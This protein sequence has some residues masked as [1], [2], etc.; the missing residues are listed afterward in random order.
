[1]PRSEGPFDRLLRRRAE[2]DPAP[3]IIGGTIAFLALVIILVF[4][5]SSI[6][7][8]GGGSS[9]STTNTGSGGN[10]VQVGQGITARKASIPG[11]P[12]G[13]AAASDYIELQTDQ[14]VPASI[15]LQLKDAAPDATGLGFYTF[16]EGRWQRLADVKLEQSGRVAS[17]DF[18]SVPKNLAVLRV[19]SQ[20][21]QIAAALPHGGSL[22]QDARA[23]IVSPRDYAPASDGSIQGTATTVSTGG[24]ILLMPTVIGSSKETAT[25]VNGILTDD[26]SRGKHADAIVA[27]AQT[28][29]LGG[30]DLE[31]SSVDQGL[32]DQFTSFVKTVA[33]GL[34]RANKKLS[35]TLP[36]PSNQQQAYD[37]KALGQ[38]ADYIKILPIAD[39]VSYWQT[40]PDSLGRATQDIDPAKLMLVVSPFSVVQAGDSAQPI[41]YVQ[42]MSL[43][44]EAVVREPQSPNDIKPGVTVRLVATN[45]DEGEGASPLRWNDD[46]AAVTFAAGG[47][48]RRRIFIENSFSFG[49]KLELIQAY[50]LGGIAV[51]DGSAQS[52]VA[53]IWPSVSELASAA[54]VSLQRPNDATFLPTWQAPEGGEL[55]AG[56]GTT[57]TWVA[58]AAGQ[59]NLVLVVSDGE[60]RFGRKT[61]VEVKGPTGPSPTPLLTFAPETGT[62]TPTEEAGTETPTPA[63]GPS[64]T[65]IKA[66][67]PTVPAGS[68]ITYTVTVENTGSVPVIIISITDDTYPG[69]TCE[70]TGGADIVGSELAPGDVLNC[71]FVEEAP[72]GPGKTVTDIVT[73]TAEDADG[74]PAT[75]SDPAVVQTT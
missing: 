59:Y 39:P 40:M 44:A 68:Q 9:G 72:A 66:S 69:V 42:A 33:D 62:P 45:L 5:F 21:Y 7:G 53:N 8:G 46:A 58:P 25:I 41:G 67:D 63:P 1:V 23:N 36:P 50:G 20:T 3:I 43:A 29:N 17:G 31:Y 75:D 52:D 13:L 47:N 2:R 14:D 37:W 4:A 38:A 35:L 54:T 73:V 32:K 30:V 26:S 16:F 60:R 70:T 18:S 55:G 22:H 28:G 15:G 56:A 27:L 34:H 71:T 49:F 12:P 24:G 6:F 74:V 65:V 64:I 61:L 11:L 51:S 57:A 48:D 10:T 19:L